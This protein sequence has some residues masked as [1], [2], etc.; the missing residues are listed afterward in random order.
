MKNTRQVFLS[1]GELSGE[2]IA[3][4]MVRQSRRLSLPWSFYGITGDLLEQAGVQSCYRYAEFSVMGLLDILVSLPKLA[5][6]QNEL[7]D[8]MQLDPPDLA[9]LVDYPGFHLQLAEKMAAIGIPV[10]QLVAP[11]LWAWGAWRAQ[12]LRRDMALVAGILPF[13][14]TFFASRGVPYTYLGSPTLERVDRFLAAHDHLQRVPKQV[15][16][17]PGSR[18]GEIRRH[19]PFILQ[20]C[21]RLR[22]QDAELRFVVPVAEGMLPYYLQHEG[23]QHY[24]ALTLVEQPSLQV[25]RQAQVAIVAS[26]TATLECA[27][28]ATPQVVFYKLDGFSYRLGRI[29]SSLTH[30]SLVNLVAGEELAEEFIQN[31][32]VDQL[33]RCVLALLEPAHPKRIHQQHCMVTVRQKL[34]NTVDYRQFFSQCEQ[35]VSV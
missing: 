1:T 17:L 12:R 20:L 26:G 30:F 24:P 11:K 15:A 21:E 18:A 22:K 6:I 14:Q 9:I 16:I 2:L 29:L 4:E 3:V 27:L 7:V 5:A 31:F 25:M 13:E 32:S 34:L 23:L 33:A 35:I 19:L 28:C 8:R 10:I